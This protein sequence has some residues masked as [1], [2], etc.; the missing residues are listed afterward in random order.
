MNWFSDLGNGVRRAWDGVNGRRSDYDTKQDQRFETQNDYQSNEIEKI[1]GTMK[2]YAKILGLNPNN[3]N[4]LLIENRI[5]QIQNN[6]GLTKL[7]D[8]VK[9]T[10]IPFCKIN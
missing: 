9:N 1:Q 2:E 8:K 4:Q 10:V 5:N 6:T 7:S 3:I